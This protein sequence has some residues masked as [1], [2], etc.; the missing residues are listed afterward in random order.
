MPESLLSSS[1]VGVV[2]PPENPTV[3]PEMRRL[4]PAELAPV[5]TRLPVVGADLRSRLLAYNDSLAAMV[6]SFG[7]MPL[8]SVYFACTGSSYLVGPDGDAVLAARLG[9]SG[10]HPVTAAGAI[11][12]T[13]RAL[14]RSR[15]VVVSPYPDWLTRE[16]VTFWQA[17]GFAVAGAVPV[18]APAGIYAVTP[19][20]VIDVVGGLQ[21]DADSA[22]TTAVLLS[23][24]GM[25]TVEAIQEIDGDLGVPVL[26]SSV[27]AAY[28]LTLAA[29]SADG[30]A[31]AL[32][33]RWL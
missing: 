1:S 31:H 8:D 4:L 14:G 20:A 25:P 21:V 26:S 22:A 29:K 13:L 27:A 23:G 9:A 10:A 16:A 12:R 30:L 33:S 5:A 17:S 18:A 24:T 7:G 3:E 19:G 32:V 28:Q 15:L 11:S 2:V 6:E